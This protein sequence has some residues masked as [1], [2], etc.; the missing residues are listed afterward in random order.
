V[1]HR[2]AVFYSDLCARAFLRRTTGSDNAV[3]TRSRSR[4][5]IAVVR[6]RQDFV[7]IAGI[8][9]KSGCANFRTRLIVEASGVLRSP[10]RNLPIMQRCLGDAET[11]RLTPPGADV[12]SG[13]RNGV[14]SSAIV[15]VRRVPRERCDL[16]R[17]RHDPPRGRCLCRKALGLRPVLNPLRS[18]HSGTG[19]FPRL[20]LPGQPCKAPCRVGH[21]TRKPPCGDI[22]ADGRSWGS[23][24]PGTKTFI[25]K[26][27]LSVRR[28]PD[29]PSLALRGTGADPSSKG[30]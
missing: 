20:V 22:R 21:T 5:P 19:M 13:S 14:D 15:P 11:P 16:F 9:A 17:R 7:K 18:Q 29:S 1:R 3:R 23:D 6:D 4:E 8:D 28:A 2:R 12:C 24:H 25:S 30:A 26:A 27:A 10:V